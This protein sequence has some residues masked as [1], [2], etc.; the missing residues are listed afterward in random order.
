MKHAKNFKKNK[1]EIGIIGAGT[2]GN[3]IAHV[4]SLFENNIILVDISSNI[5]NNAI[6]IINKNLKRQSSKG[7]IS[8]KQ[9][10]IAL[11]NI[12]VNTD[13]N[14]LKNCDFII[15]AVKENFNGDSSPFC[16]S[17]KE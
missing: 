1:N 2:M 13:M 15:E 11:Q 14:S 16:S 9:I 3:G 12:T 5:L 4:F 17:V 6:S 10:S 8:K 7:I